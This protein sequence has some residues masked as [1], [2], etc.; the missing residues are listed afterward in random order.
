MCDAECAPSVLC[1]AVQVEHVL[2]EPVL[3]QVSSGW[4]HHTLARQPPVLMPALI[5]SSLSLLLPAAAR[6][7]TEDLFF[8]V[9]LYVQVLCNLVM[10]VTSVDCRED[11]QAFCEPLFFN[12]MD[13][14]SFAVFAG[15]QGVSQF[16]AAAMFS[17]GMHIPQARLWSVLY[18]TASCFAA[19]LWCVSAGTSAGAFRA[20]LVFVTMLVHLFTEAASKSPG[21]AFPSPLP[22]Y[23]GE[24]IRK[25]IIVMMTLIVSGTFSPVNFY[26]TSMLLAGA[27]L[28]MVA[29]LFKVLYFDLGEWPYHVPR[30]RSPLSARLSATVLTNSCC[31]PGQHVDGRADN[32][33]D[34]SNLSGIGEVVWVLAVLFLSA[35]FSVTG[36]CSTV[37][38][39][40][41]HLRDDVASVRVR[42]LLCMSSAVGLL[43]STVTKAVQQVCRGAVGLAWVHRFVV[44][45]ARALTA[46]SCHCCCQ[47]KRV[48]RRCSYGGR[49]G[50][51]VL[52]AGV[53]G[54]LPVIVGDM[55]PVGLVWLLALLLALQVGI[56]S[57]RRVCVLHLHQCWAS[58]PIAAIGG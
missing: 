43:A 26:S 30:A 51:R 12:T 28:V 20:S 57:S 29:V 3:P 16:M 31:T 48:P 8:T 6:F 54:I 33:D 15:A 44:R 25:F 21:I 23:L 55:A 22:G 11:S 56:D 10:A 34:S 52:G 2:A 46:G 45:W 35:S 53:I 40:H 4:M 13:H 7:S 19:V 18:A 24:R 17:R 49:L 32:G 58:L 1:C 38:V 37:V 41:P 36:A 47:R 42:W 14:D 5:N 27:G 9:Y 39:L 50:L